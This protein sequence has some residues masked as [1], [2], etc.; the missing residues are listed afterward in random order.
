MNCVD[1]SKTTSVWLLRCFDLF[2]GVGPDH[3]TLTPTHSVTS[4]HT[5]SWDSHHNIINTYHQPAMELVNCC[6]QPIVSTLEISSVEADGREALNLV[7]NDFKIREK[8]LQVERFVRPPIHLNMNLSLPVRLRYLV[9]WFDLRDA[10]DQCR[11][12]VSIGSG[13]PVTGTGWPCQKSCGQF[14]VSG[15]QPCLLLTIRQLLSLPLP[16]IVLGSHVLPRLARV[17]LQ[18]LK[19]NDALANRISSIII[20]VSRLSSSRPLAIKWLELWGLPSS[21]CNKHQRRIFEQFR[22]TLSSTPE[23]SLAVHDMYGSASSCRQQN[24]PVTSSECVVL[25]TEMVNRQ[26]VGGSVVVS[27]TCH[28]G[29]QARVRSDTNQLREPSDH[30]C[31][32]S[33]NHTPERFLDEITCELMQV[34]MMLPSGHVVDQSTLHR[35]QQSDWLYGRPASDPFTGIPFSEHHKAK[36]CSKLKLEIDEFCSSRGNLAA[37]SHCAPG[38]RSVGSAEDIERHLDRPGD[39]FVCC[40]LVQFD[41]FSL[42]VENAKELTRDHMTRTQVMTLKVLALAK[43]VSQI[44]CIIFMV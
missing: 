35:T 29:V 34:P 41:L 3:Y 7:S 11:L 38:G 8:G 16:N 39:Y 44:E 26:H 12:D 5:S 37:S 6:L 33:A 21:A 28:R 42:Q 19:L 17:T 24:I 14:V 40:M 15:A 23:P 2:A 13:T 27:S 30:A 4:C 10:D 20:S 22:E 1:H 18:P 43:T 9:I 32:V 31:S 25:S 36:F